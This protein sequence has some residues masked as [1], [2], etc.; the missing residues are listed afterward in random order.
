MPLLLLLD[1][2][3]LGW[4]AV[5]AGDFMIP[6]AS[7]NIREAQYRYYMDGTDL[8]VILTTD[9]NQSNG[10]YAQATGIW[11]G[12]VPVQAGD[13]PDGQVLP[14]AGRYKYALEVNPQ[15]M[16]SFS[17]QLEGSIDGLNW[18]ILGTAITAGGISQYTGAYKYM[19]LNITAYTQVASPNGALPLGI[20]ARLLA[21]S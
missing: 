12:G 5:L 16:T 9:V 10:G 18:Y 13:V 19:R 21:V 8:D 14:V 7:S 1:E 3:A 20:Q 17:C 11:Y 15:Q 2:S 4:G 6:G